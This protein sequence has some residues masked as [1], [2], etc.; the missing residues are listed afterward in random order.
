MP[1]FGDVA[2]KS[3]FPDIKDIFNNHL[4]LAR[5]VLVFCIHLNLYRTSKSLLF[6]YL[7]TNLLEMLQILGVDLQ[8]EKKICNSVIRGF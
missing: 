1:K 2:Q 4:Q 6:S 8:Q 5:A 3:R 7:T